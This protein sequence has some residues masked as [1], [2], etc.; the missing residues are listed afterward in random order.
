M[1]KYN[2]Q[3]IEIEY[4]PNQ[5]IR[6][7]NITYKENALVEFKYETS[8]DIMALIFLKNSIADKGY[9]ADLYIRYMPYSRMDREFENDLFLLKYMTNIINQLKFRKVYVLEPHSE[10]TVNL[11]HPVKAIRPMELLTN[12][13]KEKK[14]FKDTDALVFPDKGSYK[15]Y[16]NEKE[17]N[18]LIF[19]KKRDEASTKIK[20]LY[21]ETGDVQKGSQYII[22]DDLC[23][24]GTTVYK[25]AQILKQ[26][27]AAKVYVLVVHT[28]N[29][30]TINPITEENS[31]VDK[32]Y[33]T[34]SLL[35]KKHEK[36]EIL[37]F[38][39]EEYINKEN[40]K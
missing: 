27:G 30:V 29:A 32:I 8:D 11:L 6:I 31:P 17:K 12:M 20:E 7:R 4:F 16:F 3:N 37:P 39:I 35:T 28:E 2:N 33:T 18:V 24:S 36:I 21:L 9:Q 5:E 13:V 10:A 26:K 15:R 40:E 19:N 23:A 38:K 34:D 1:I 22:I 14:G 25:A